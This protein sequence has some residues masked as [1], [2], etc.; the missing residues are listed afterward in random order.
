MQEQESDKNLTITKLNLLQ[1]FLQINF[2]LETRH[3]WR[4][5]DA[6]QRV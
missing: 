5:I 2:Y 1:R 6:E 3:S 4:A